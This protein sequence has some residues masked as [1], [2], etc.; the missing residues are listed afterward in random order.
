[1]KSDVSPLLTEKEQ[2]ELAILMEKRAL[3][4]QQRVI[5]RLFFAGIK[6][7]PSLSSE[8]AILKKGPDGLMIFLTQRPANDPFYPNQW[9]G[10]G[11][12]CFTM[13]LSTKQP[14]EQLARLSPL[15]RQLLS[16]SIADSSNG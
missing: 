14:S 11:V 16:P 4:P 15:K 3:N 8:I 13:N 7:H 5:P 9:H 12:C 6:N 2:T 1:M 10:P